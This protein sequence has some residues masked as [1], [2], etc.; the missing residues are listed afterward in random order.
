MSARVPRQVMRSPAQNYHNFLC[1]CVVCARAVYPRSA[2]A[3]PTAA[4]AMQSLCHLLLL[5]LVFLRCSFHF[6]PPT[7]ISTELARIDN[8]EILN[9][10]SF[11]SKMSETAKLIILIYKHCYYIVNEMMQ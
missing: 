5:P 10:T 1:H 3:S 6:M 4:D 8:N 2:L 11:Y 9:S 7:K